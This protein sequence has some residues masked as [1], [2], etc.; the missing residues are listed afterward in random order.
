METGARGYRMPCSPPPPDR[1]YQIYIIANTRHAHIPPIAKP[2]PLL[3][4]TLDITS[5]TAF[6]VT[7]HDRSTRLDPIAFCT[8]YQFIDRT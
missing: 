1:V 5:N 2:P 6:A 8:F 4:S 7:L 3:Y